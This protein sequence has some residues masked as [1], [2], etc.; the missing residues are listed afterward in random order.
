MSIFNFGNRNQ[1]DTDLA[2]AKAAAVNERIS[3]VAGALVSISGLVFSFVIILFSNADNK[4]KLA[5]VQNSWFIA[6]SGAI[7][8]RQQ[9]KF[10]Q[11]IR[12]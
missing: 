5:L 1:A 3:I 9:P 8:S 12:K 6:G 2:I 10:F 4:I 7:I 11:E